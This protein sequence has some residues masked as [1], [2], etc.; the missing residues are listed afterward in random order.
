M[1]AWECTVFGFSCTARYVRVL[2]LTLMEIESDMSRQGL[3]WLLLITVAE[4]P[5]TVC[6]FLMLAHG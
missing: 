6:T 4:I 5:T 1:E 2:V 3:L